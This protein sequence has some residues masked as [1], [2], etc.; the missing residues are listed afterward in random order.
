MDQAVHI[1]KNPAS[2]T[3]VH[4]IGYANRKFG[5]LEKA[6]KV[7]ARARQ[8]DPDHKSVHEYMGELRLTLR[9]LDRAERRLAA[10][11]RICR[12]GRETGVYHEDDCAQGCEDRRFQWFRP[13]ASICSRRDAFVFAVITPLEFRL[14]EHQ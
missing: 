1:R 14:P 3:A 2:A 4:W 9:D 6:G 10:L 11:D 13:Y 7:Y 12:C 8:L 5:R